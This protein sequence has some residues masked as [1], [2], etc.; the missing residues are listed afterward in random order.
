M[1]QDRVLRMS[2]MVPFMVVNGLF[3][4]LACLL[5]IFALLSLKT[6]AGFNKTMDEKEIICY[7]CFVLG[8][9]IPLLQFA[10]RSG[11]VTFIVWIGSDAASEAPEFWKNLNPPDWH[12]LYIVLRTVESVSPV[13]S[14]S[15]LLSC[16]CGRWWLS[17]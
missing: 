1:I 8:F 2:D 13:F 17:S 10:M 14:L 5:A 11:P 3:Q 4:S 15:D 16:L 7:V 6:Q 9:T 12:M